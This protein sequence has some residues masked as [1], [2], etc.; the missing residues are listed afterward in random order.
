MMSRMNQKLYSFVWIGSISFCKT[1]S[2][3]CLPVF[4]TVPGP[5]LI[6]VCYAMFSGVTNI[7]TTENAWTILVAIQ[8]PSLPTRQTYCA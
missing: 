5:D 4:A 2:C 7:H 3:S 8:F 1:G 6:I